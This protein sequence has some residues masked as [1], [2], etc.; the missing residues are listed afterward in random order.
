M[1]TELNV[2]GAK[3]R[4]P[5]IKQVA[6]IY[7]RLDSKTEINNDVIEAVRNKLNTPGIFTTTYMSGSDEVQVNGKVIRY[8]YTVGNDVTLTNKNRVQFVLGM[9]ASSFNGG[10]NSKILAFGAIDYQDQGKTNWI[11]SDNCAVFDGN[12]ITTQTPGSYKTPNAS[13]AAS[14]DVSNV[15]VVPEFPEND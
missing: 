1:N 15:V 10:A 5:D 2:Y 7:V 13:T 3:D 11:Y 8:N 14:A 6:A 9:S 4:D 12:V